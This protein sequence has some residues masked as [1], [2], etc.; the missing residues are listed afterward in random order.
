MGYK[1]NPKNKVFKDLDPTALDFLGMMLT[2]DVKKRPTA[3]EL[4]AHKFITERNDNNFTN[5]FDE[6]LK[7]I[8]S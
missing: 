5:N 4:L 1:F 6:V 8:E 2:S 3:Q 7:N